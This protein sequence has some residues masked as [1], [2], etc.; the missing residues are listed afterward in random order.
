MKKLTVVQQLNPGY[1]GPEHTPDIPSH[2]YVVTQLVN[3]TVP[4]LHEHLTEDQLKK[5]CTSKDWTVTVK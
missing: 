2:Q 3:S 4:V 5:Y 1:L